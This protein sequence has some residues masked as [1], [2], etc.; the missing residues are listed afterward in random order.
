MNEYLYLIAGLIIL[1][2]IGVFV[3]ILFLIGFELANV[4]PIKDLRKD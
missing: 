4:K 3:L 2:P 1:I